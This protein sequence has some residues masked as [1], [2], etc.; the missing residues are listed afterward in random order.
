MSNMDNCLF[1]KITEEET[2]FIIF[3][4]VD[5]TLIFI[6][7]RQQDIVQFVVRMNNH[8]KLTLDTKVDSFLGINITHNDDETVTLTYIA[9]AAAE[10]IQ[11]APSEDHQA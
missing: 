4:F 5:D 3:M 1:Y 9:K 10:V 7:K 2:T 6:S 11:G 8:Y